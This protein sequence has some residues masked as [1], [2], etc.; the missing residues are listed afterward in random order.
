M[1]KKFLCTFLLLFIST[2]L[3]KNVFVSSISR[4][5]ND[6]IKPKADN[7][8]MNDGIW[9]DKGELSAKG[10]VINSIASDIKFVNNT[11]VKNITRANPKNHRIDTYS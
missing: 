11:I 5:N 3:C 8:L 6:L 10:H 9:T 7:I 4:Q 2:A 1:N